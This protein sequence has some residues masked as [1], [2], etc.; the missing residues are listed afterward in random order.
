MDLYTRLG[1]G[2]TPGLGDRGLRTDETKAIET[3]DG[4]MQA[5]LLVVDAP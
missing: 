5:T 4:D 2:V 3:R 1:T